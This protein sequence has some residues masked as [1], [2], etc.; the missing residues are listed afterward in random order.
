[1]NRYRFRLVSLSCEPTYQFSIDGHTLTVIEAEGTNTQPVQASTIPIFASQRYSFVVRRSNSL[2][3]PRLKRLGLQLEANQPVGNYWI[4]ALPNFGNT[5]FAGGINSAILRYVGAPDEEPTK[6]LNSSAKP[7]VETD[8]HPLV[9][10][11]PVCQSLIAILMPLE[12]TTSYTATTRRFTS[13]ICLQ[14]CECHVLVIPQ[15]YSSPR[16]R[17]E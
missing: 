10:T 16:Q 17:I 9:P 2:M 1:M 11:P 3:C 8:L 6:Q 13:R 7:L 15:G 4:R 5:S 14:L 12:L